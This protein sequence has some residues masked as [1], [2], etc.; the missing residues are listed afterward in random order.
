ML[1]LDTLD[2]AG[3]CAALEDNSYES[4]WWLDPRTGEV[5]YHYPDAEDESVD[6]STRP[7]S[8]SSSRSARTRP[9]GTWRYS[10]PRSPTADLLDRA[11]AGRGAFRS[12]KDTLFEFPELRERW[13]AYHDAR[14]R[15]RA[16]QWLADEELISQTSPSGIVP[17]TPNRW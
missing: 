16:I 4:S 6:D 5:R 17:S 10:S 8:S 12:F 9:T 7:G 11:I 13:F 15:Q 2:M 1:D 14:M 3:L